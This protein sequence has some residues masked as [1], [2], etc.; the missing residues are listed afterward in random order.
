M[1]LSPE[2]FSQLAAILESGSDL[3]EEDEEEDAL[4]QEVG[5][6]KEKLARFEQASE[7]LL[8]ELNSL[9]AEYE[10]EKRCREQ[11]ETYAAQ[12]NRE[13]KKLKRISAV[14]LPMLSHLPGDF[15][16]SLAGEDETDGEPAP[17]L[18]CQS[19]QQVK[20]LQ[21]RVSR[22]LC[23]KKELAVRVKELQDCVQRLQEQ[24]EEESSEKQS[25]QASV[26]HHQRA[27]KRVRQASRL[28]TKEYGEVSRQLN[29]EQE[30]RQQAEAFARQMLVAQ[31]EAKRQSAILMQSAGA[32]AQLLQA[33][34]E[35]AETTGVLEGA[36]LEHQAKV[37]DLEAQLAE[38]PQP[39]EVH[40]LQAALAVAEEKHACL[41]R[42]LL[43][44]EERNTALG[45]RVDPL[46]AIRQRKGAR[47]VKQP[48]TLNRGT[49]DCKA[50]AV[51][52]MMARIRSGVVLRSTRGDAEASP[53]GQSAAAASKRRSAVMELQGLL[54]TMKRPARK[55]SRRKGSQK[56]K[57]N[58]LEAILQRR[59]RVVDCPGQSQ[60]Q[61]Q[62]PATEATGHGTLFHTGRPMAGVYSPP[63]PS[64]P[65]STDT[66]E[67]PPGDPCKPAAQSPRPSEEKSP[68][69]VRSLPRVGCL[70][71][72]R[73]IPRPGADPEAEGGSREA[74]PDV[75][76]PSWASL[77][78]R[79]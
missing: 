40:K 73:R 68:A 77:E 13:N 54:R 6:A 43:Q 66:S 67:S 20:D 58:Q 18:V 19:L 22:L 48:E 28:V 35:V 55:S 29:L 17:D 31:E 51:E 61:Q 37:K 16:S 52:E 12:V 63:H 10:I 62:C 33:L 15:A 49:D 64:V 53:K 23:E 79:V 76:S 36:R 26:E 47:Q 5:E 71:T 8:A 41:E 30:L 9:E 21:A 65:C 59:R 25:L 44:A 11:A 78:R 72:S 7:A 70:Q 57:D 46:L 45:E 14:L 50:K 60:A 39:E 38:R 75:G 42:Q 3:S 1:E 56:H 32:D 74:S 24:L 4:L 2:G 27:L 34:E 69:P